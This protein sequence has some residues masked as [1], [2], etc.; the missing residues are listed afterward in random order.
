MDQPTNVVGSN[1]LAENL[2]YKP[3]VW[4]IAVEPGLEP[5]PYEQILEQGLDAFVI[6]TVCTGGVPTEEGYSF[7]PLIQKATNSNIPVYLLRGTLT[8]AEKPSWEAPKV[9]TLESYYR[10]EGDAIRAGAIPLERPDAS[11]TLEVM[12]AIREVYSTKPDFDEGI[13][14]VS[15]MFSRP[16]FLERVREIRNKWF[17]TLILMSQNIQIQYFSLHYTNQK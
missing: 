12:A 17:N 5:Q 15:E 13:E 14:A 7:I 6:G 8:A 2:A 16:E 9:R 1:Q 11:Q 4:H 10:P 3:R